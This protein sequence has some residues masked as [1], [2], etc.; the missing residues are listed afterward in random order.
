MRSRALSGV[1]IV[2]AA[3]SA[4]GQQTLNPNL[5]RMTNDAYTRS[6]DYDIVHQRIAVRDFNWDSTSFKGSV[7][8]TLVARRPALDSVILDAGKLLAVRSVTSPS[9]GTLRSSRYGDTLVV[10]L[11]KPVAMDDTVRFT[12]DYDARIE[13]GHG[14]TFIEQRPK[15][16]RQIWSQG[17]SMENHYWFPTY[18]FPNDK[19]TWELDATVPTADMA[20]SN[21]VLT[22]D[23]PAGAGMHTLHWNQSTP[24]ATYLVSLVV[25]PLAKVHDTY[26]NIPMDAYVYHQDSALARPLFHIT[27]DMIDTYARL[28]GVP[29]PWAKYAQTTVADFFG[30]MENVSAT[31]LVDWLPDA[32]AYHDR[33][34]YQYTLIPHELAHQ[35]FGDY[36]T[37]EN[38]ANTWLNEGFAEFMPGQ[39]WLQKLGKHAAEDYYANEYPQYLG[40]ESRRPMPLASMGS[41]NIYPK[42]ALVLE[43]LHTYLGDARFW[44]GLHRYLVDHSLRGATSDDLRQAFLEATGENLDWF[45]SEWIYSAGHPSFTVTSSYDATRHAVT[46]I[47]RQTQL[48]SLKADSTGMRYPIPEVFRMPVTVRVGTAVGDVVRDAWITQREDTIVVDKVMSAPTMIVFDDKNQILKQLTFDQPT[49]ALA[50]QLRRDPNLW[51][52]E[53]VIEQLESRKTDAAAGAA[54]AT[55]TTSADYFL[56]RAGAASAL[57]SFP[58]EIAVPALD[59]AMRDTSSQVRAAAVASLAEVGGDRALTLARAAWASDSSYIVRAAG[60]TA[61]V[62]LDPAGRHA[63]ILQGLTTPSYMDAIQ[64]D[65]LVAVART[66]D[67]TLIDDVQRVVGDQSLPSQVLV[68][69][70]GRGSQH[71]TELV[72]ADLDDTRAWV[73]T[74]ML[75]ATGSLGPAR[76]LA[77]LQ[78]VEP[79][80]THA[81]TRARVA[82]LIAQL[83]R[84]PRG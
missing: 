38:W 23:T 35:W 18:D 52:R 34:W 44:A 56:T 9:G 22:G 76:Q 4:R 41:N 80:L 16:P 49:D 61:L 26:K 10:H 43:M 77:L 7:A 5:E 36:V 82:S 63:L 6:H 66:N 8:T 15:S 72:T 13:S 79:H 19:M 20:V 78:S 81:D 42:G 2:L 32:R 68:A 40:Y 70:S 31:T 3:A 29:F 24:S 74:W 39:Y 53:W 54:L 62:K 73:R 50:T 75:S 17:E 45:W 21:G 11:P 51:N 64:N 58:A 27:A 37:T 14:L 71:A 1:L 65:A 69:F 25:A 83:Q 57:E 46:L 60:L 55:A 84:T 67:T 47:A 33:P 59:R 28:T 12:I 30:G 48:D